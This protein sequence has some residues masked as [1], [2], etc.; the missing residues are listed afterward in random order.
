MS[1]ESLSALLDGECRPEELDRLLDDM[2]RDPALKAQ[3]SRL[4]LARDAAEGTR[5]TRE[6]RCICAGVMAGI[7]AAPQ[8]ASPKVVELVRPR[9]A[10]PSWSW[11]PLAGLAAAAAF[12]AVAVLVAVPNSPLDSAGTPGVAPAVSIPAASVPLPSARRPRNLQPV[13]A[14]AEQW[15]QD[16]LRNYLIEHSNSADRGVGGTLSYARFA[17]HTAEYRPQ[18]QESQ[19]PTTVP[20]ED[21]P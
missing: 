17:A 5:V 8:D 9:A 20:D 14:S 13:A 21:Q 2:E 6:Q 4:C 11:K 3:F 16:D 19:P 18:Q 7:D 12:G 1:Q 15:Q 10:R